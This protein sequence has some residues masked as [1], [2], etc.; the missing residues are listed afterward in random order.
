MS[1][2]NNPYASPTYSA[3]PIP[4]PAVDRPRASR[5]QRFGTWF[6]DYIIVQVLS[7]VAGFILG[8][9]VA[10]EQVTQHGSVSP[11]VEGTIKVLGFFLGLLVTVLCFVVMEAFFQKTVGKLAMG[12]M[13]VDLSGNRPTIG[14]IFGRT[15]CRF[16]P[17]EAFSFLVEERPRGWHDSITGTQVISLR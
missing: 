1:L 16:I 8:F 14:Q 11:D 4:A 7:M 9:V 5:G 13:V 12:T 15:A 10:I 2:Q 17:F 6:I 3:E